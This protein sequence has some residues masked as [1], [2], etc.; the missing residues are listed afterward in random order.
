MDVTEALKF[1]HRNV[2]KAIEDLPESEWNTA[3][4]CGVWSVKDII[5]HLASYE[6][7]LVEILNTYV[8][9]GPTPC[10]DMMHEDSLRFND[11]QVEMR[12]DKGRAEV[13]REY[14]ETHELV[15][16]LFGQIP[17]DLR[18]HPER[19]SPWRGMDYN[20]EEIVIYTNYAHKCEHCSQIGVFRDQLARA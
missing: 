14:S 7:L 1:G 9:S 10:L 8:G 12:K 15:L 16:S 5:A 3:G 2:L 20:L 19:T 4:V 13:L 17:G 18:R 6:L 11:I